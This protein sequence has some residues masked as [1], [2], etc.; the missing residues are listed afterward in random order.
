[1]I[2]WSAS[3]LGLSILFD[4]WRETMR[5]AMDRTEDDDSSTSSSNFLFEMSEMEVAGLM[6]RHSKEG[7]HHPDEDED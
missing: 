4:R 1:M 3:D 7:P 5:K 6:K 2:R